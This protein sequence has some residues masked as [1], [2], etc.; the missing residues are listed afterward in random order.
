LRTPRKPEREEAKQDMPASAS[1][2]ELERAMGAGD[3]GGLGFWKQGGRRG[4]RQGRG[5]M[6]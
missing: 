3:G 6:V 5:E 1:V 4:F 2:S